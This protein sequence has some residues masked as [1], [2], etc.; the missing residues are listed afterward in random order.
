MAPPPPSA[1]AESLLGLGLNRESSAAREGSDLMSTE[2]ELDKHALEVQL[3]ECLQEQSKKVRRVGAN[4]VIR[5]PILLV[6][7]HTLRFM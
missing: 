2:D 5:H 1:V 3:L 6:A 4:C 7:R